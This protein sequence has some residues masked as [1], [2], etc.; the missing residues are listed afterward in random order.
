MTNNTFHGLH[1]F[2]GGAVYCDN[3]WHWITSINEFYSSNYAMVGGAIYKITNGKNL[4]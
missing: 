3:P 1:S 2:Y 4:S